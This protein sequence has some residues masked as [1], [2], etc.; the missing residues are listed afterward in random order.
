MLQVAHTLPLGFLKG[1]SFLCM[2]DNFT[3]VSIAKSHFQCHLILTF[4]QFFYDYI[5]SLLK[6]GVNSSDCVQ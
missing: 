1:S 5:C 3:T 4:L 2:L 6:D